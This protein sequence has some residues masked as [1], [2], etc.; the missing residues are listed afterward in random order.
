MI[1]IRILLKLKREIRE[2]ENQIGG[3]GGTQVELKSSIV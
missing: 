2:L 3:A 1:N